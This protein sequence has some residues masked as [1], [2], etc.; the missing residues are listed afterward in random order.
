MLLVFEIVFHCQL[1]VGKVHLLIINNKAK[2][3]LNNVQ[4]RRV[5]TNLILLIHDV[6]KVG[7][8]RVFPDPAIKVPAS[9]PTMPAGFIILECRLSSAQFYGSAYC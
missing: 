5:D 9:L 7:G 8:R 1:Q 2:M 3:P 4:T 6:N